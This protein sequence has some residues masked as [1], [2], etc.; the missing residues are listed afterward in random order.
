MTCFT[1]HPSRFSLIL[2]AISSSRGSQ[3]RRPYAVWGQFDEERVQAGNHVSLPLESCA[4]T[5]Y[6]VQV[7][8]SSRLHV[9]QRQVDKSFLLLSVQDFSTMND[10]EFNP[11]DN[12][13]DGTDDLS[14]P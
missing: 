1:F 5:M 12:H 2:V 6:L 13:E 14:P 11:Q 8:I 7:S 3:N 9:V 10:H 4:D